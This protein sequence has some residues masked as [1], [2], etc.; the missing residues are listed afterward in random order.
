MDP[1]VQTSFIPK[2]PLNAVDSRRAGLGF[3]SLIA[4]IIFIASIGLAAGVF[5]Y[6]KGMEKSIA[7]ARTTLDKSRAAFDPDFIK[8]IVR[9]NSRME[10]GRQLLRTHVAVSPIFEVLEKYTLATVSFD[11]MKFIKKNDGKVEITMSGTARNYNSIALQSDVFGKSNYLRDALFE[12]LNLDDRGNVSFTF[13]ATVDPAIVVYQDSLDRSISGPAAEV[14][15][16]TEPSNA[17][18]N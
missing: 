17:P 4:L 10:I 6:K 8:T 11:D 15:E 1:K 12:D 7:D 18:T 3:F 5:I 14:V 2:K 16:T 13:S 9:L